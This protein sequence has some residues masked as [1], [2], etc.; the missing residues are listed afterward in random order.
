MSKTDQ[1]AEKQEPH[2]RATLDPV[3]EVDAT[4]ELA[5]RLVYST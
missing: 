3:E 1:E 4:G 2:F 5:L